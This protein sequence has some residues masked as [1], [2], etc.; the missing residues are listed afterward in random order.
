ML[1]LI[2]CGILGII[3]GV[4]SI[5]DAKRHNKRPVLG[6]VAIGL[7]VLNILV[8]LIWWLVGNRNPR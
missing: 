3:F 6:Y 7:S 1:G 5:Q 8:N 2:C 4:L